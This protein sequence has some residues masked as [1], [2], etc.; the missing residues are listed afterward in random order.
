M[1]IGIDARE[2]CGRPTG[3]GRYLA[4]LLG[5]WAADEAARAH[6]FLLYAS[7][8]I[9]LPLDR[10]RFPTR[11]IHG[12]AGWRWEQIRLPRVAAADHLDV[13]FAP[14]YTAPVRLRVPIVA[15]IHDVSYVA[16][17]EWFGVRQG[18]R[19][20]W[21]TRQTARIARAIVTIS[22]FSK[23][24]IVE[25]FNVPAERIHVIPPGIGNRAG[26]D[27]R[28]GP[29]RTKGSAPA[30]RACR[31]LY[32]GTILNRRH[33]PDLIRAF[34]PIA[35]SHPDAVLDL[36]GDNR[37]YPHEDLRRIID[38]EGLQTTVQWHAYVA[39]D[40]LSEL[41]AG[42]RA[43]AFLSEYEGL[44]LTPLEALAAGV[45][46]VLLD[47]PVARESCGDAAIYVPPNDLPAVTRALEALLFDAETR[48][49]ILAAAP[50]ALAKYT[51]PR[52]ARE[53][54]AVLLQTS[55]F[56]PQT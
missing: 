50:A 4:G 14:A 33:V 29:G 35:R 40:Q 6:E 41:Y 45:P 20:R 28:V 23:R 19:R 11:E 42:A 9:A 37:S 34:A 5:E 56:R 7:D 2:L 54:L 3:A 47:T 27:A 46:P 48:A 13:W 8:S 1:R 49:R 15:A 43:F 17:P 32:V 26:A 18:I 31:V 51:W 53:T 36:V 52:A 39:D 25:C 55:A 16:H 24:E 21:L 30:A 38:A 12:P 10:H 44:G 22:E